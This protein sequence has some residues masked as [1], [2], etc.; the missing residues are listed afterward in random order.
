MYF[1][2]LKC[3]LLNIYLMFYWI[4]YNFQRLQAFHKVLVKV[5]SKI[6][7]HRP[8]FYAE[9]QIIFRQQFKFHELINDNNQQ[10]LFDTIRKL[11]SRNLAISSNRL[12]LC[13]SERRKLVW[14]SSTWIGWTQ[15]SPAW[16]GI[17][18][19]YRRKTFILAVPK[20][21]SPGRIVWVCHCMCPCF[22]CVLVNRYFCVPC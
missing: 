20:V 6:S 15:S 18:T 3:I 11:E 5:I 16:L 4:D 1:K 9:I 22:E 8:G 2:Y 14:R 7:W 10:G 13:W 19:R 17:P 12:Y 21:I